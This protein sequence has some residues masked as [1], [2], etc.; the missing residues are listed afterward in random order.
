MQSF[1][2]YPSYTKSATTLDN[3]R[4]GCQVKECEQI[5]CAISDPTYGWQSHPAVR[6]W[7]GNYTQL[8][9]YGYAMY[10]E[11]QRRFDD[12]ERGGKRCHKSGEQLK[13]RYMALA[14]YIED[15]YAPPPWLGDERLHSS[16]R[17]CLLAKDFEYYSQFGWIEKPTPPV[18]GKWPYWWPGECT[19]TLLSP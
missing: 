13:Q 8:V 15:D 5:A 10:Q 6:M 16:H 9:A 14:E 12:D 17:A 3:R 19:S 11:W 7:H 2:P 4:L 1:L 18:N